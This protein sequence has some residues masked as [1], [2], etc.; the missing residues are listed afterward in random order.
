MTNTKDL[1]ARGVLKATDEHG[2]TLSDRIQHHLIKTLPEYL[3]IEQFDTYTLAEDLAY[4]VA[5]DF[6]DL[7]LDRYRHGSTYVTSKWKEDE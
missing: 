1:T 6:E 5:L 7:D 2:M 3:H 4:W